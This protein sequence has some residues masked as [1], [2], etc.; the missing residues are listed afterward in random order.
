MV[1]RSYAY[2]GTDSG[3]VTELEQ[4]PE[5]QESPAVR[6]FLSAPGEI[7]TPD[8]RFRRPTFS[9]QSPQMLA[10]ETRIRPVNTV[11]LVLFGSQ[12]GSHEEVV[13]KW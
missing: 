1:P 13:A 11:L 12:S 2:P 3:H 5:R 9:L 8:L 4:P 7:R 6:G 10:T